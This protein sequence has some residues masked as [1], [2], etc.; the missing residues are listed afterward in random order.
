MSTLYSP[1][2]LAAGEIRLLRLLPS[3][4]TEINCALSH[5]PLDSAPSYIPISY[6]WGS[7][8][9]LVPITVDGHSFRVTRNLFTVLR[10]LS[11]HPARRGSHDSQTSDD[12]D[13][14]YWV[15]ALCID[16]SNAVERSQQV[17][18]MRHIY[19]CPAV[20][21]SLGTP[22][23]R[24]AAAMEAIER[25]SSS[26]FSRS[27]DTHGVDWAALTAFFGKAWFSRMW[28]VQEMVAP[29]RID[30]RVLTSGSMSV[31]FRNV[32]KVAMTLCGVEMRDLS[33]EA[34]ARWN[35][36]AGLRRCCL[37][38]QVL[39]SW[40]YCSSEQLFVALLW[41]CR[42]QEATDPRDKIYALLGLFE[43]SQLPSILAEVDLWEGEKRA[44]N[45]EEGTLVVDYGR[46]VE[47]VY[48]SVVCAVV[49]ATGN[50]DVISACQGP[51]GFGRSWVPDWSLPWGR[52]SL[53]L[54]NMMLLSEDIGDEGAVHASGNLMA[55][56]VFS[57]DSRVLTVK[58]VR[59][60]AIFQTEEPWSGRSVDDEL[61]YVQ[62]WMNMMST[63]GGQLAMRTFGSS[64]EASKKYF[65]TL[66]ASENTTN[67]YGSEVVGEFGVGRDKAWYERA[68]EEEPF[69]RRWI[70]VGEGRRVVVLHGGHFALVPE[71]A[72][73]GDVVC[74][75]LGCSVP[76]VLRR[77]REHYAFIG[78]CFLSGIMQGELVRDLERLEEFELR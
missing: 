31:T 25:L 28:I 65:E 57:D 22:G 19:E 45:F 7:T 61:N 49:R 66:L 4:D 6:V 36:I 10:N 8:A 23:A 15:D 73:V 37:L 13:G 20:F 33:A 59:H 29:R 30:G 55:Q 78:E 47:D 54:R 52:G 75:L 50:L 64:S 42:D 43:R 35:L 60:S 1:L 71:H 62:A 56:G 67:I 72:E 74:V 14:F 51:S 2:N 11:T 69:R 63:P 5:F 12:G 44:P 53:L 26:N 21:I 41:A 77:V 58:G 3:T 24:D 27:L 46:S 9:D 70:L 39:L 48:A 40:N 38:G 17:A 76:A 16:Q 34:G 32:F 18:R 68:L